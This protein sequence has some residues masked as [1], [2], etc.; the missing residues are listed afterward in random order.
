[1]KYILFIT[2]SGF[3]FCQR[4]NDYS[5]HYFSGEKIM[6]TIHLE[7]NQDY[8]FLSTSPDEPIGKYEGLWINL[9]DSPLQVRL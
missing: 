3:L 2:A 6:S 1:M 9:V 4:E 8:V 7:C 5:P